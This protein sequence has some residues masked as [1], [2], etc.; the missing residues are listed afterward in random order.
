[1]PSGPLPAKYQVYNQTGQLS[2]QG[3]LTEKNSLVDMAGN[4]Q[5]GIYLFRVQHQGY[6]QTE[7]FLIIN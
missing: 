1:M 5:A 4:L 7:K 6:S 3:I 2:I